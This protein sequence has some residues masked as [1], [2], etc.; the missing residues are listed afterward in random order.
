MWVFF[1]HLSLYVHCSFSYRRNNTLNVIPFIVH[2]KSTSNTNVFYSVELVDLSN[3]LSLF[4][5][6]LSEYCNAFGVRVIGLEY[7]LGLS[8]TRDQ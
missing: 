6:Q 4:L 2:P 5:T 8:Y 3:R 7:Q 1:C